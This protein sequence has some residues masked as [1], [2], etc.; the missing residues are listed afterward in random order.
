[1]PAKLLRDKLYDRMCDWGFHGL[2]DFDSWL[3]EHQWISAMCDLVAKGFTFDRQGATL[4]LRKRVLNERK[5]FIVDLL[6]GLTVPIPDHFVKSE[7]SE[8]ESR[9][10]FDMGLPDEKPEPG[11]EMRLGEEDSLVLSAPDMVTET[12]GILARRG[13]GKT[14]LG[15]VMAEE[16]L[17]SIHNIP[18]VV[19]DPTGGWW[20]LVATADGNPMAKNLVVFGGDHGHY[21]L[22]PTDGEKLARVVVDMRPLSAILDLSKMSFEEQHEFGAD[23]ATELYRRNSEPLHVFIDEADTF[24]PQRLDRSSAHQRRSLGVM[25]TLVRRGRLRGIGATMIT[26]RPA[27]ISKDVLS[28]IGVLFLLRVEAPH[29]K[30]AVGNWLQGHVRNDVCRA[31]LADLPSLGKGVAYFMQGGDNS[32]FCRF[33]VRTKKTYDS[34]LTPDIRKPR[35]AVPVLE[36]A[37]P[38]RRRID[39]SMARAEMGEMVERSEELSSGTLPGTELEVVEPELQASLSK[40]QTRTLDPENEDEAGPSGRERFYGEESEYD[41]HGDL[42]EEDR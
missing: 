6:S 24:A 2:P 7:V 23:F 4:R 29:D 38:L 12:V 28:Q 21:P 13:A 31:C 30:E 10:V 35:R 33:N 17:T 32:R 1:M 37:D 14:Y 3:P 15:M 22:L 41:T 26:Q 20:G 19:L 25:S 39:D 5:P 42:D 11:D 34:S 16:F 18:F 9:A 36:L 27:V 8:E 40:N